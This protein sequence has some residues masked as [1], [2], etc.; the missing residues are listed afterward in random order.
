MAYNVFLA[1]PM[2]HLFH[3]LHEQSYIAHVMGYAACMG[4]Y[5]D[6]CGRDTRH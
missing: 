6:D 1:G 4:P 3:R 2:G 5:Q